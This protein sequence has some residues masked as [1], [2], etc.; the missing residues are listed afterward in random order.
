MHSCGVVQTG[1]F[2]RTAAP[3]GLLGLSMD[4]ISLPNILASQG[5]TSNSYSM[6]FTGNGVGTIL[7]GDRDSNEQGETPLNPNDRL[8]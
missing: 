1:S 8:K 5:F 3:N 2:L 7:F 4:P 6:C